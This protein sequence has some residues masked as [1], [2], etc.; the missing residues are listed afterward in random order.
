V[1]WQLAANAWWLGPRL[2]VDRIS[3]FPGSSS[4]F[5]RLFFSL[6]APF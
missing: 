4:G 1:V 2:A 3:T 5:D 6:F